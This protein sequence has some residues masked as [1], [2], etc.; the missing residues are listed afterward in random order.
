MLQKILADV[1]L[2]DTAEDLDDRC[3]HC[4][5]PGATTRTPDQLALP[6]PDPDPRPPACR[7]PELKTHAAAR[8]LL[9][10][11]G[12]SFRRARGRRAWERAGFARPVPSAPCDRSLAC[13]R[14]AAPSLVPQ[15]NRNA[16]SG[17]RG[18]RPAEQSPPPHHPKR[19]GS[20]RAE[21]ASARLVLVLPEQTRPAR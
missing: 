7:V 18:P 17:Q 6:P 20:E 19:R 15:S 10:L 8:S 13:P 1:Q 21:K 11:F 16:P 2:Q 14:S 4:P 3:F 5:R 9:P 12:I